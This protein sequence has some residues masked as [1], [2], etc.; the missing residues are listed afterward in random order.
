MVHMLDS[1]YLTACINHIPGAM[2]MVTGQGMPVYIERDAEGK[3]VHDQQHFGNLYILFEVEF[4]KRIEGPE[5]GSMTDEQMDMLEKILP[6]RPR[7]TAPPE[8]AMVED[9]VLAD[10]DTSY[11]ARRAQAATAIDEDTE[12]GESVQCTSQ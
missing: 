11:E 7:V 12:G 10:S 5:G 9:F 1:A 8:D 4:P 2:K 6:P 3:P